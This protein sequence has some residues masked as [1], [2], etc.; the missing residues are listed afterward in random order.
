MAGAVPE[1]A[2]P[3]AILEKM[4]MDDHAAVVDAFLQQAE[5]T[6][7]SSI[8][9]FGSSAFSH[10]WSIVTRF[11]LEA[12]EKQAS[13]G[14]K[15]HADKSTGKLLERSTAEA[16]H[17]PTQSAAA[18]VYS[19]KECIDALKKFVDTKRVGSVDAVL[20]QVPAAAR[21][22]LMAKFDADAGTVLGADGQEAKRGA[23]SIITEVL[24]QRVK[25][26][27][28]SSPHSPDLSFQEREKLAKHVTHALYSTHAAPWTFVRTKQGTKLKNWDDWL[29]YMRHEPERW[30]NDTA[31]AIELF[32]HAITAAHG[33]GTQAT[34]P[35]DTTATADDDTNNSKS[36]LIGSTNTDA[37]TYHCK[38]KWLQPW[39]AQFHD[40]ATT[41]KNSQARSNESRVTVKPEFIIGTSKSILRQLVESFVAAIA[42][43][44]RYGT[45]LEYSE[46]VKQHYHGEGE[47]LSDS[48][49]RFR[50]SPNP[51]M[52]SLM[53]DAMAQLLA[54]NGNTELA[55]RTM[56]AVMAPTHPPAA[57]NATDGGRRQRQSQQ[58]QHQSPAPAPAPAPTPAPAPAPTPT[59]LAAHPPQTHF[60]SA[61]PCP[62]WMMMQPPPWWSAPPSHA[63]DAN[64]H[65]RPAAQLQQEPPHAQQPKA[66][67][68]PPNQQ[69]RPPPLP[70]AQARN[71]TGTA[72]QGLFEIKAVATT[73]FHPF[74]QQYGKFIRDEMT[75]TYNEDTSP[76]QTRA[77]TI[78]R[79]V[80]TAIRR[81]TGDQN[82]CDKWMTLGR[83]R[84]RDCP[85]THP[86]WQREWDGMWLHQNCAELAAFAKVPITW[87]PS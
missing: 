2:I 46:M 26:A 34:G 80:I 12:K 49:Q 32:A 62:P 10:F 23:L 86:E 56:T 5:A 38:W 1:N 4:T 20:V 81:A 27:I 61:P 51:L 50:N 13:S 84:M 76:D 41:I 79:P 47:G 45:P 3:P 6:D 69:P 37:V 68:L 16:A 14:A 11:Q 65:Q 17:A 22:V 78:C 44:Q 64:A 85:N 36:L 52:S 58:A 21:A 66:G 70:P 28:R 43:G 29:L 55:M 33:Y 19:S 30:V 74:A 71:P 35:A 18:N 31:N 15:V 9:P 53:R 48:I 39:V 67:M 83:C 8:P 42:E 59:A 73:R 40:V 87:R 82:A 60:A 7:I 24:P 72:S 25:N 54:D 63:P 57:G 77:K 75:R